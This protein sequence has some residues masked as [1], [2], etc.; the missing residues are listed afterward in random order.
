[1]RL[2]RR[3]S[4]VAAD[5]ESWSYL[6]ACARGDD[7]DVPGDCCVVGDESLV[8]DAAMALGAAVEETVEAAV[9]PASALLSEGAVDR[10]RGSVVGIA[11]G[12]AEPRS[13][14]G[15]TVAESVSGELGALEM[16]S[17][18]LSDADWVF[19]S[20][21][22]DGMAEGGAGESLVAAVAVVVG[23]REGDVA[24][25]AE[26]VFVAVFGAAP[27]LVELLPPPPLL[28]LV[29]LFCERSFHLRQPSKS[30]RAC[31]QP[32]SMTLRSSQTKL[33]GYWR[34]R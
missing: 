7:D 32:H 13:G 17:M 33:T 8:E 28:L 23:C 19:R 26:A 16:V 18:V 6:P 22:V 25:E 4:A 5:L 3:S 21:R 30:I 27:G 9:G 14:D 31:M 24:I 2:R 1:M 34:R 12:G 11:A 20:R 15:V 10:A 29:L